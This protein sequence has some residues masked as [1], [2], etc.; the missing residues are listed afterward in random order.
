MDLNMNI[1]NDIFSPWAPFDLI[2]FL[3]TRSDQKF[4]AGSSN[5]ILND[6]ALDMN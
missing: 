2:F 4:S 5:N 3:N 6:C 1:T